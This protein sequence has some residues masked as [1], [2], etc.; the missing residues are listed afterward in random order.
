MSVISA[1][2]RRSNAPT[3]VILFAGLILALI[4]SFAPVYGLIAVTLLVLT[5]ALLGWPYL[6]LFALIMTT[7]FI[8]IANIP[9]FSFGGQTAPLTP[10][11]ILLPI[12]VAGWLVRRLMAG[13]LMTDRIVRWA[14]AFVIMDIVSLAANLAWMS[15]SEFLVASLYLARWI[16]YMLIYLVVWHTLEDQHQV[17]KFINALVGSGIVVVLLGFLQLRFFP[18][19]SQIV[20]IAN[21]DPASLQNLDPHQGR[22]VSVFLEPNHLSGYFLVFVSICFSFAFAGKNRRTNPF[23]FCLLAVFVIAI[24][25]TQSRAAILGLAAMALVMSKSRVRLVSLILLVGVLITV[26][27]TSSTYDKMKGMFSSSQPSAYKVNIA[28]V[29]LRVDGSAYL[30]TLVWREAIRTIEKYPVT[31]CGYNAYRFG[32]AKANKRPLSQSRGAAGAANSYLTI[33]ATTGIVGLTIYLGMIW[34]IIRYFSR[35]AGSQANSLA[36]ILSFATA[37][38]M[39]G[40]AVHALSIDSLLFPQIMFTMWALAGATKAASKLKAGGAHEGS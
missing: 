29:N 3:Y 11:D 39:I 25:L 15:K 24:M 21:G 4:A 1:I 16:G 30:R 6:G 28:G 18:N 34:N 38:A 32:A 19:V 8:S 2:R 5:A 14:F 26:M 12:V 33:L 27:F 35:T 36:A 10:N 17:K 9:L 13:R 37:G 22:L 31:G 20:A 7:P 40:L 23:W